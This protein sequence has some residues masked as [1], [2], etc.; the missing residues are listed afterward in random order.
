IELHRHDGMCRIES[1]IRTR[2]GHGRD[3]RKPLGTAKRLYGSLKH[4]IG[5]ITNLH[6][7]WREVVYAKGKTVQLTSNNEVPT[8]V[9]GDGTGGL[10]VEYTIL[11][12]AARVLV[13]KTM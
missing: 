8:H 2:S 5:S 13:P 6:L 9:D 10:P 1:D 3:R 7:H 11:P 12:M 4:F